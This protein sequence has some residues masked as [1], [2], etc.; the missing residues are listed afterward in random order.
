MTTPRTD[1]SAASFWYNGFRAL[2]YLKPT[3][4]NTDPTRLT[5]GLFPKKRNIGPKREAVGFDFQFTPDRTIVTSVDVRDVKEL[6]ES[7]PLWQRM[8]SAL[9]PG[10]RTLVALANNLGVNVDTL[11]RTVRRKN[12]LFT[13]VAGDDGITRIALLERM[14]S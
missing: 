9:G 8:K 3:V 5:I 7:L 6:A 11:D 1:P 10:P 13:R 4:E 14:A 12:A 2:W